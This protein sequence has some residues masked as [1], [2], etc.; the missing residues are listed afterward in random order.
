MTKIQSIKSKE[1]DFFVFCFFI[2]YAFINFLKI[3]AKKEKKEFLRRFKKSE[4]KKSLTTEILF[5]S[6]IFHHFFYR[7]RENFQ[8]KKINFLKISKN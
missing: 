2:F 7:K 8:K 1:S 4:N 3:R 6:K 5:I